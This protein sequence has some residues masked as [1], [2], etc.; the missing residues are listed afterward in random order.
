[1]LALTV[2]AVLGACSSPVFAPSSGGVPTIT[3]TPGDRIQGQANDALARWRAAVEESGGASITF[4]GELTSQIGDWEEPVGNNNKPALMAGLIEPRTS[5]S[6]E[7][8]G[9]GKVKWV[10]GKEQDVNVLSAAAALEELVDAADPA[11]CGSDCTPLVVTEASLATSLVQTSIG[12]AEA[13]T[14][15]FTLEGTAVRVTRVAVDD[16]VTVDPPPWNA[17][18][19]PV[20]ISIDA[21]IGTADSS[22]FEALF[23]GAVAG[24]DKKCGADYT[25]K[26]VE[27]ELAVVVIVIEDPN[28]GGGACPAVGK[29]RSA[30]VTLEAPLGDR[31][32][33][34]VRQGLP[35]TLRP[36]TP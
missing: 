3:A 26:A 17:E 9:R 34:E 6:S 36:P 4:T 33:L 5:L 29:G 1:M 25:A 22:R 11:N 20:G 15:V 19:P 14:W 30:I 7:R 13:P 28:R 21:A 23:V 32:V 8:P 31:T 12:P 16:S 2:A 27:S 35:V 10:D 24:K 18:D